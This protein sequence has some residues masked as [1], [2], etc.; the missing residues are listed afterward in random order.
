LRILR[1]VTRKAVRL[2]DADPRDDFEATPALQLLPLGRDVIIRRSG[3]PDTHVRESNIAQLDID[4]A[5]GCVCPECGYAAKTIQGLHAHRL[6]AHR[7]KESDMSKISQRDFTAIESGAAEIVIHPDGRRE[8][9]PVGARAVAAP[10][11]AAPPSEPA[12]PPLPEL[13]CADCGK[14]CKTVQGLQAHQRRAHAGAEA[15]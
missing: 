9:V 10:A 4:A 14:A 1:L 11:P 15:Q 12:P 6:R 8:V 5:D 2:R 13:V 7:Q 3:K